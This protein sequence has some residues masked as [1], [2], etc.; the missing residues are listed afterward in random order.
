MTVCMVVQLGLATI[1]LCPSSAS[2]L[3]SETTSGTS[4]C[5]RHCDELSTTTAPA[6]AKRGAH[7]ALM[8]EPAEKSARSKPRDRLLGQGHDGQVALSVVDRAPGGALGGEGNDLVGGE[9]ALAHHAEDR[10][11]HG[12][13]GSDHGDLHEPTLGRWSPATSSG[14]TASAPSP[15]AVCS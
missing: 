3:T 2:G 5:M 7:S 11:A 1:P 9:R 4:S 6:S 12:P 8:L 10:G 15:K 13:G 14:S